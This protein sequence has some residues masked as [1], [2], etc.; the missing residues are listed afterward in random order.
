[1]TEER[2]PS[3]PARSLSP[4]LEAS[5][6]LRSTARVFVV[7]LGAVAV[8]VVA[9]LSLTGLS[10]LEPGSTYFSFAIVGALVATL[11]VVIMLALAM[12]LSSASAVSMAELIELSESTSGGRLWWKKRIR[13]GSM[14]ALRVV[15]D[16]SN[17]CLAGY[18]N[19]KEFNDAVAAVYLDERQMA[20]EAAKSPDNA[21]TYAKYVAAKKMADW[22]NSRLSALIEIASFQRL[23]WNFAATAGLMTVAGAATAIG[24]VTYA[25]ALQPRDVPSSPVSV[26]THQSI[27]IK[28][29]KS[30]SA[31]GLY[32]SMIGCKKSVQALVLGV[33][34]ASVSAITIP[35]STCRSITLTATW[36]GAGYT[37]KFDLPKETKEAQPTALP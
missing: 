3:N 6:R 19:L 28:I 5:E 21:S 36:D 8:T 25:A 15:G 23:R 10:T 9:G 11:G 14:H 12:R 35:E 22:Y 16:K 32:E 17:S 37:A 30:K 20:D 29:P 2:P 31:A 1:M 4:W 24:I 33:K 18:A 13:R 26:T 34:D 7:S 27:A